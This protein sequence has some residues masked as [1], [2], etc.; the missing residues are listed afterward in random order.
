[1]QRVGTQ[2]IQVVALV[3]AKLDESLARMQHT[4]E[5]GDRIGSIEVK[6]L[7][8]VSVIGGQ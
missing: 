2:C 5:C 3:P 4:G 1:M 7:K 8:S 6:D